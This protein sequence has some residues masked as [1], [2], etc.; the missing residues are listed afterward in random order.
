[1]DASTLRELRAWL[2]WTRRLPA[3]PRAAGVAN[4]VARRA[5]LR[6]PRTLVTADVHGFAMTLDPSEL[7]DGLLLFC[8]HLVDRSERA[9][10]LASLRAGDVFLD[11]GAYIGSYALWAARVV[12]H[13]GRVIAAEPDAVARERLTRNIA[14]ND[15]AIDVAPVAL[16]DR[17][18][19][20]WLGRAAPGN[21]GGSSLLKRGAPG[22]TVPCTTLL[23]L[24]TRA[25]V[26]RIEGAKLDLEGM[27][28]RVLRRFFS[29]APASLRPGF[30]IVEHHPSLV[31]ASG[32]DLLGLLRQNGYA[33]TPASRH[34]HLAVRNRATR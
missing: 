27:E 10:L 16:S 34:N 5:F 24:V 2:A 1:M 29:D 17:T 25:G 11:L 22:V 26:R 31:A 19:T 15:L 33:T 8:P 20:A 18:G 23:D 3:W 28:F 21:R 14:D 12:G 7:V 30:L 9:F 13:T 6:R 32:G 4:H